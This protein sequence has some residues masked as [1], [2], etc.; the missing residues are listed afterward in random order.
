[1]AILFS[2]LVAVGL[3]MGWNRSLSTQAFAQQF[4]VWS[5]I[6]TSLI[7]GFLAELLVAR[8]RFHGPREHRWRRAFRHIAINWLLAIGVSAIALAL[9]ALPAFDSARAVGL[10]VSVIAIEFVLV[11]STASVIDA[12][13]K[14]LPKARAEFLRGL[15]NYALLNAASMVMGV[16]A[17]RLYLNLFYPGVG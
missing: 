12:R 11:C 10:L 5:C 1:M 3:L 14:G 17:G 9:L 15:G 4:L 16:A 6:L 13:R 7:L 2:I 8:W